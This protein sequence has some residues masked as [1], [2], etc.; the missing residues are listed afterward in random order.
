MQNC[1]APLCQ[2]RVWQVLGGGTALRRK[3]NTGLQGWVPGWGGWYAGE[4]CLFCSK[5]LGS[6]CLREEIRETQET[7]LCPHRPKPSG[8]AMTTSRP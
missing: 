3:P 5:C 1:S 8:T 2:R 7:Q 4:G 6:L